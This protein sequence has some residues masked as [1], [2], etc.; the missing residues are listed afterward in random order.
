MKGSKQVDGSVIWED[1]SRT[2]PEVTKRAAEPKGSYSWP[3]LA[4]TIFEIADESPAQSGPMPG[5]PIVQT[6][7]PV[8]LAVPP[9]A[10]AQVNEP[11]TAEQGVAVGEPPPGATPPASVGATIEEV[12]GRVSS[13]W[14]GLSGTTKL[15]TGG[16]VAVA[17]IALLSGGR[18][19]R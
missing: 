3:P 13:W 8:I 18:G 6:R 7:P 10:P 11:P 2:Y 12:G 19:S 1:G 15:V 4:G 9:A 5:S 16:A 14:G 17:A